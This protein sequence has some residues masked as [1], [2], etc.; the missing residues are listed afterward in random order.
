MRAEAGKGGNIQYGK[1]KPHN[2][3]Q[4]YARTERISQKGNAGANGL[5]DLLDRASDVARG[6]LESM[7]TLA[8]TTSCKGVQIS[9]LE[10]WARTEGCWF[11][12]PDMLG[13][14][15][16]RGSE[17]EVYVSRDVQ[18][19]FKLN[20]LRYSDDNLTPFFERLINTTLQIVAMS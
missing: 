14:Y 16:D 8:G 6:T 11:D 15:S 1:D 19:M 5:R 2:K 13:I 3:M 9:A 7:Q 12:N 17:N 18:Y 4:N 20:D 10:K